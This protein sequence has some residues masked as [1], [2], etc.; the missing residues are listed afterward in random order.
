[1]KRE[2]KSHLDFTVF[3]DQLTL[4]LPERFHGFKWS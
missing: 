2:N 1:M 4:K 3:K